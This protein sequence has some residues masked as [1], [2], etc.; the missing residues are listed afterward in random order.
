MIVYWNALLTGFPSCLGD[1]ITF[2]CMVSNDKVLDIHLSLS[3][4]DICIASHYDE[5]S[6]Y[7]LNVRW[8][9]YVFGNLV[10]L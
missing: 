6:S 7:V 2:C 4:L 1:C 8:S 3:S 10:I 5:L 9:M